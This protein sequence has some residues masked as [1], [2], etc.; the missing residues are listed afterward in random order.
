L[1]EH[2]RYMLF[3]TVPS[4]CIA[5][6][7]YA[8]LGW[9]GESGSTGSDNVNL[10]REALETHFNLNPILLLPPLLVILMVMFRLP[11]LPALFGGALLGGILAGVIQGAPLKSIV[12]AAQSGYVAIPGVESVDTLLSRGGL[13]NMLP[14]VSLILAALTFGGA[15]ERTGL[16]TALAAAILRKW[17]AAPGDWSPPP[18][19]PVSA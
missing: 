10:I 2:I 7:I 1:F 14:T 5:L 15:M 11:A 12:A 8:I 17:P 4:L 19:S 9:T 6:V 13:D 16:L 18:W 3:T